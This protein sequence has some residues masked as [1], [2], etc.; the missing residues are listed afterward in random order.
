MA[1]SM[2]NLQLF[3][4]AA[5]CQPIELPTYKAGPSRTP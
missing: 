3:P 1:V 5:C 4:G 2:D